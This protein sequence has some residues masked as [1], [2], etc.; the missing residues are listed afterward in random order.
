MRKRSLSVACERAAQLEHVSKNLEGVPS[1]HDDESDMEEENDEIVE[2]VVSNWTESDFKALLDKLRSVVPRKDTKKYQ[3]SLKKIDWENVAFDGHTS[4][5]VK[6]VTLS[7]IN[8]IRK[9]RTLREMIEDIPTQMN[10]G[11]SLGKP[12]NPLSAYNFFMKAKYTQCK[13]KH[14]ELPSKALF[15]V[16]HHEYTTLSQKKKQKYEDMA[17][18]AKRVYKQQMEEYQQANPKI[19]KSHKAEKKP[20]T[21]EQSKVI[22]P[23]ALFRED[24]EGEGM[25]SS[26]IRNEWNMLHVK[27]KL[28]YIQ[29]AY[30]SQAENKTKSLKLNKEEKILMEHL[31]GKPMPFPHSVSEYY[32]KNHADMS[33]ASSL[34]E[35]R[36]D[37]LIE[38]K[39]LPKV[40]KLELEIEYRQAK[41][42]YVTS[43]E[44][45][46]ANI[47]D[48]KV[49][50]A[51]IDQLK[52][53]IEKKFDKDDRKQLPDDSRP[54]S[55]LIHAAQLENEIMELP[56]A[57]ST[58]FLNKSNKSP[59][60]VSR[61]QPLNVDSPQK[62]PLKSILKTS[63]QPTT[64]AKN[65][66][67]FVE[68]AVPP[69]IKRKH[70]M[71]ENDSDSNSEKKSKRAIAR[72]PVVEPN[73]DDS[74]SKQNGNTTF[75]TTNEPVRP[76]TKILE[77]YKQRHYLGKAENC[78]ESFK[79]LSNNRK[80]ALRLEMRAAQKKY[81]K[82]L[83]KF[84]KKVPPQN[85][86]K[87]L[88]KLK[89]AQSDL[90][91]DDKSL[92]ESSSDED[93][94]VITTPKKEP[95]TSSSS[96]S[97]SSDETNENGNTVN[98]GSDSEDD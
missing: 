81:F 46:I 78:A 29:R 61:K 73:I 45:Y 65:N 7:L 72:V 15:K 10:K 27:K 25:T 1:D 97:S 98:S 42:E 49:Q 43:Y 93:N 77:F 18:E 90:A 68:P 82:E 30:T 83:Q 84:L 36:K 28:Q 44:N 32:L 39:H 56:I 26:D 94:Q 96:E 31:H 35:W 48:K 71:S 69:K 92:G 55:S 24:R 85:I 17:A 60:A 95:Q 87:Y 40:R 79:K 58:T 14:P 66:A 8:K 50:E 76:P 5:E 21:T 38:F 67:E 9:Y 57:E 70:S 16:L 2:T 75:D 53:F 74:S 54:F 86:K 52:S 33:N 91:L 47:T 13:E 88:K 41:Q 3:S 23:F 37:K 51:E 11:Y 19:P 12:K 64:D 22:T 89:R 59:K 6:T 20:K 62:K 80:E 34:I 63:Q 4:D